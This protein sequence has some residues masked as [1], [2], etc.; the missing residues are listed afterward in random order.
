MGATFKTDIPKSLWTAQDS[1][2]IGLNT[3][4]S[5]KLRTSKG[6]SSEGIGFKKYSTK[7]IY[8]AH[9]VIDAV[10]DMTEILAKILEQGS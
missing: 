2:T 6:I 10:D 8:V 5:I 4:A 7:P 3:V 1:Q 9:A